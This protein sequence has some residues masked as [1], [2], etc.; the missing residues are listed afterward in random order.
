MGPC[1]AG[2][3]E[4][5]AATPAA[6]TTS[7]IGR[8]YW[9]IGVLLGGLRRRI[10]DAA[11]KPGDVQLFA[12]RGRAASGSAGCMLPSV[13]QQVPSGIPGRRAA[14]ER[15]MPHRLSANVAVR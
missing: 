3:M 7:K 2:A 9:N 13:L 10:Y 12:I 1:R 15:R 14:K 11:T 8:Q 5:Q 6:I 4:G